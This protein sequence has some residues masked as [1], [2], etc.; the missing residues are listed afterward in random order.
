MPLYLLLF[1]V[2]A[3][4][5]KWSVQ[6]WLAFLYRCPERPFSFPLGHLNFHSSSGPLLIS[7]ALKGKQL[8]LND[9]HESGPWSDPRDPL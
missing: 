7:G 6:R 8:S 2:L 1:E 9:D 4:K 5:R 3:F